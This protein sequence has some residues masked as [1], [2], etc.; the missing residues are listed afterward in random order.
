MTMI[1]LSDEVAKSLSE[2]K[3]K[4]ELFA[5]L[6]DLKTR[7]GELSKDQLA[8]LLG[9]WYHPLHYFPVF[10]S[11]IISMAP[12][13]EMQ[14][15]ICRILWQELGEGDPARSHEKLFI[16]TFVDIGIEQD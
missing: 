8:T 9:Q 10:L 6:Q 4:H 13:L 5:A 2:N 1:T 16:E 12:S 3:K 7:A 15:Y 11:R 14:T